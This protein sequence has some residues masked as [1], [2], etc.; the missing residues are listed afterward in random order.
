MKLISIKLGANE[1]L[2]VFVRR[3]ED[4]LLMTA[5]AL[6]FTKEDIKKYEEEYEY[7][8]EEEDNNDKNKSTSD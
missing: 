8:Y 2:N 6:R 4:I 3:I 7:E 1:V 5:K